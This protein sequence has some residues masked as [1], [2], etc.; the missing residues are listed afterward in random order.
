MEK[1]FLRVIKQVIKGEYEPQLGHPPQ[2][3]KSSNR[4]VAFCHVGICG[5]PLNKI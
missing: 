4:E 3:G 2:L 5:S 1:V